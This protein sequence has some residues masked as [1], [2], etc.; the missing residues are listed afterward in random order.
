[1]YIRSFIKFRTLVMKTALFS[2]KEFKN[3]HYTFQ[4]YIS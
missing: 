3:E 4:F 1:M 2:T